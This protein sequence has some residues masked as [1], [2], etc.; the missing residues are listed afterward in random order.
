MISLCAV[1]VQALAVAMVT[2]PPAT[3][4]CA[5][6]TAVEQDVPTVAL[7]I[8]RLQRGAVAAKVDVD[9]L[10]AAVAP[11]ARAL[12]R[13]A[14]VAEPRR[15]ACDVLHWVWV[16]RGLHPCPSRRQQLITPDCVNGTGHRLHDCHC[17]A[18]ALA[19]QVEVDA[20]YAVESFEAISVQALAVAMV[21]PPPATRSRA[22]LATAGR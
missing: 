13:I 2:P 1:S 17:I 16:N 4:S 3:R 6:L 22:H 11:I 14:V 5:H 15:G 9:T 12:S 21:T 8:R 7:S 18:Y 10:S 19:A 20:R